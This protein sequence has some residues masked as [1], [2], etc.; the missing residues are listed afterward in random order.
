V[1]LL[2][3][4]FSYISPFI[5]QLIIQWITGK[6]EEHADDINYVFILLAMLVGS[7]LMSYILFEH[8]YYY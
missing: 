6:D 4:C 5:V 7:Q 8:M 3:A 1:S 2:A